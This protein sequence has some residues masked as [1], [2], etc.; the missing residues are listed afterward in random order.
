MMPWSSAT[1][2]RPAGQRARSDD[3]GRAGAELAEKHLADGLADRDLLE[4]RLALLLDA[5]G[6]EHDLDVA[7]LVKAGVRLLVRVDKVLNLGH[8][9]LAHAQEALPG[10]NLVAERPADLGRRERDAAV[11]ELEQAR[12]VDEVALSSLGAEEAAGA[13]GSRVSASPR[14][15]DGR[16]GSAGRT[17]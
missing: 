10:R 3:A 16:S 14:S 13:R 6:Q 1:G 5:L 2:A 11:V 8:R 12:E 9:E 7:D 15:T 17:P 4:L